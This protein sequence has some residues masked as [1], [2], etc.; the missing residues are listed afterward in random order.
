MLII[1]PAWTCQPRF[2]GF[3]K[4]SVKKTLFLP[5]LKDLLKNPAGKLDPLLMQN[6]LRLVAWAIS[7]RTYL[8]KEYQ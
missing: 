8:Q 5:A 1:T 3:L 2:P 7:G 4:L 6:S